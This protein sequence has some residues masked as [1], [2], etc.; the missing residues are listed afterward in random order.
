ACQSG[1]QQ[2]AKFS[3]N[4]LCIWSKP[5]AYVVRIEQKSRLKSPAQLACTDG[6]DT[7][8]EIQRREC[9]SRLA[10]SARFGAEFCPRGN[11]RGEEFL[12]R[13]CAQKWVPP[14]AC[15]ESDTP[16]HAGQVEVGGVFLSGAALLLHVAGGQPLVHRVVDHPAVLV[17]GDAAADALLRRPVKGGVLA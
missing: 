7:Y 10:A 13:D 2:D 8:R 14:K 12:T 16:L 4:L 5:C 3:S 17:G 15:R 1:L 11:I 9:A 6:R